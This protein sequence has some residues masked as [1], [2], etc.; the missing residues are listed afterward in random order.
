MDWRTAAFLGVAYV[1]VYLGVV[2]VV[3]IL[4][5]AALLLKLCQKMVATKEAHDESRRNPQKN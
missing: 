2:I 3:P 5:I 4:A 1:F